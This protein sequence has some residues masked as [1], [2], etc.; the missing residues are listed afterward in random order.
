[1]RGHSVTW[2]KEAKIVDWLKSKPADQITPNVHRR[3]D[4]LAEHYG[5]RCEYL[6]LIILTGFIVSFARFKH[7]DVNN[8]AMHGHWYEDNT[9]NWQFTPDL[10]RYCHSVNKAPKYFTNDFNVISNGVFTAFYQKEVLDYV[11]AGV[12]VNGMGIQ[13]H[14]TKDLDM[15]RIKFRLDFLATAGVPLWI[16]EFDIRNTDIAY[17]AGKTEDALRLF[18]SHPAVEGIVLWT[19]W[20]GASQYADTAL[21]DGDD[22]EE[23]AAGKKVRE[24]FLEEWRTNES[25]RLSAEKSQTKLLRAFYGTH[26]LMVLN[27]G[28][29]IANFTFEFERGQN[30]EISINI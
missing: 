11:K 12:P 8:E 16:T 24:L 2:G 23:N 7:W 20:D 10:I 19:F 5:D 15:E 9:G 6:G 13:S 1:I 29:Q 26:D 14:L 28:A 22:F 27:G 4:Y 21:V 3:C 25:I 18:F 17:R 30:P